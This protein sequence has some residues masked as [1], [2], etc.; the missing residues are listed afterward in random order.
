MYRPD[1][2]RQVGLIQPFDTQ[3]SSDRWLTPTASAALPVVTRS[4][5]DGRAGGVLTLRIL[6]SSAVH[7]GGSTS[8]SREGVVLRDCDTGS[9]TVSYCLYCSCCAIGELRGRPCTLIER[10]TAGHRMRCGRDWC[11]RWRRCRTSWRICCVSISPTIKGS[12]GATGAARRA[13]AYPRDGGRAHC[14]RSPPRRQTWSCVEGPQEARSDPSRTGDRLLRP[15][16]ERPQPAPHLVDVPP[17]MAARG[18]QLRLQQP[19]LAVPLDRAG[20]QAQRA[21]ELGSGHEPAVCHVITVRAGQ[22][23]C[24]H[25]GADV[26][27][28]G[29]GGFSSTRR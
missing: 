2:L 24:P 25:E 18:D 17:C 7:A 23:A 14:T 28:D 19:G 1:G 15:L 8:S 11:V 29:F 4:L 13:A 16:R 26:A 20:R 3:Y 5:R 10:R 9:V 12:A 21:G 27:T 22:T 6:P